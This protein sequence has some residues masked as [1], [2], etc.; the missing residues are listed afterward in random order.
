MTC[1]H[2]S[3]SAGALEGEQLNG[4]QPHWGPTFGWVFLCAIG[5]QNVTLTH[6]RVL[7][8]EG[9]LLPVFIFGVPHQPGFSD[10]DACRSHE[11]AG[12]LFDKGPGD[13]GNIGVCGSSTWWRMDLLNKRSR[14]SG[15]SS[16]NPS[17]IAPTL[18]AALAFFVRPDIAACRLHSTAQ[19]RLSRI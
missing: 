19:T 18:A 16:P 10:A 3:L 17:H 9:I 11:E 12:S 7:H 15:E 1:L 5:G 14:P 6:S 8:A 4:G 2:Q 13:G